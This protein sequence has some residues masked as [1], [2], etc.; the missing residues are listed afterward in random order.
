MVSF[1]LKYRCA[2]TSFTSSS[3]YGDSFTLMYA[4]AAVRT[5]A[6]SSFPSALIASIFEFISSR[7]STS[8]SSLKFSAAVSSVSWSFVASSNAS[9]M[10]SSRDASRASASRSASPASSDLPPSSRRP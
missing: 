9:Q 7:L 5:N 3:T 1:I 2:M 6:G 10:L 8:R 4:L